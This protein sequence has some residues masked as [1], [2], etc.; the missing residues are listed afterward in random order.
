[1][2][3]MDAKLSLTIAK[4]YIPFNNKYVSSSISHVQSF[5]PQIVNIE[6]SSSIMQINAKGSSETRCGRP[7]SRCD[8]S[9]V[10]FATFKNDC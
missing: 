5:A 9:V 3:H 4:R 10:N 1:M 8:I 2:Q 6:D 7:S